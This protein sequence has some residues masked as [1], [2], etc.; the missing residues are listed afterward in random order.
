MPN[1]AKVQKT[2]KFAIPALVSLKLVEA[3]SGMMFAKEV[4]VAA[5]P[6]MKATKAT[7]AAKKA[8]TMTELG[9]CVACGRRWYLEHYA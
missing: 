8:M 5:R 6:A 1:K 9:Q 2:D 3:T 7:K 4:I